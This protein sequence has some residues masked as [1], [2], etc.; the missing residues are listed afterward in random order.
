MSESEALHVPVLV[1]LTSPLKSF[2]AL[3]LGTIRL[4]RYQ[5]YGTIAAFPGHWWKCNIGGV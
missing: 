3:E 1:V 2:A 4:I 5:S